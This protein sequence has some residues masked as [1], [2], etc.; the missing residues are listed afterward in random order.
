MAQRRT[1][2]QKQQAK[3]SYSSVSYSVDKQPEIQQSGSQKVTD[4]V[5]R[6]GNVSLYAYDPGLIKGDLL[7]TLLVSAIV[8]GIELTLFWYF[9]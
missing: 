6:L 9:R 4:G 5:K 2:K 3:Y 8:I 7:K 1:K